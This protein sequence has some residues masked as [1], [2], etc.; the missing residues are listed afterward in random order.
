MPYVTNQGLS[1]AASVKLKAFM[2]VKALL[3]AHGILLEELQKLS[4]A[5]DQ[6][7]DIPEFVSKRNDMK[8]INS[9]PQANQ[10]TTEVEISGQRMPQNGLEVFP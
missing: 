2:I 8:L 4:K 6:A 9:V 1:D 3:T 7:I 10:F 5:V